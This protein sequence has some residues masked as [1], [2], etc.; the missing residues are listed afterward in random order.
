MDSQTPVKKAPGVSPDIVFDADPESDKVQVVSP[1]R[2]MWWK[3]RRHKIAVASA[4]FLILAYLVAIFAGFVAPYD[5][6]DRTQ[7]LYAPPQLPRFVDADGVFH[8]RPFV[9]GLK[10][11]RDPKTL[12][13]VYELDTSEEYPLALFVQGEPYKILGFI[14]WD[15]HLFGAENGTVH[16]FGTDDLGRDVLSRVIFG[17]Q[18]SLSVGLV[19]VFLSLIFGLIIGGISGLYGGLI[20]NII[21]RII[22]AIIAIP[23]IPLWMGLAAAIPR[24]WSPV[25]QYFAILIVLSLISW[26]STARVARGKFLALREQDFVMAARVYGA[27]QWRII[28]RYLIPNIMSYAIVNITL[29]IPGIIIAETALSFLGIGLNPPVVSWGVL[30]K[31]AQKNIV[32]HFYPWLWIGP[33]LCIIAVV[34]AFNFVGDGA[35]DAADPFASK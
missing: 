18:I 1:L 2:L 34:L 11:G 5:P 30:L 27:G 25:E 26:T 24:N 12:R 21:Q 31:E 35:R 6:L 8:L 32:I 20:D 33:A 4:V 23:S 22:E 9:Y 17:S 15:I 13:P 19:A 3:F 7:N 14:Q 16:L 28:T 10:M 29:A